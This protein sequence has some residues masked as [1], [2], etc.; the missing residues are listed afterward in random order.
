MSRSI[1]PQTKGI[2]TN[3]IRTSETHL[4]IISGT[5]EEL[6]RAQARGWHT[7]AYTDAHTDTYIQSLMMYF[8]WGII[9]DW[10]N[11]D[12]IVLLYWIEI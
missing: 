5:R 4:V 7:G 9:T 6:W 1:V 11:G 8:V 10:R 3:A 12:F 2:L